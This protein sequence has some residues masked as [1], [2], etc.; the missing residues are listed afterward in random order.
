MKRKK[1]IASK[2]PTA[3]P[4]VLDDVL[5]EMERAHAQALMFEHLVE[6]AATAF[7]GDDARGPRKLMQ[8]PNGMKYRAEIDDVREVESTLR[9]LATDAR[10]TLAR[11]R[12]AN[13]LVQDHLQHQPAATVPAPEG[14]IAI[15]NPEL[16]RAWQAAKLEPNEGDAK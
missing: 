2:T 13:V 12:S 15:D 6:Y 9:R 10:E 7:R 1:V 16:K 5:R 8:M 4:Q 11:F 14:E 3:Q